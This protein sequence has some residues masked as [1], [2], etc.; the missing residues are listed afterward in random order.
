MRLR[1]VLLDRVLY[2]AGVGIPLVL[3][4]LALTRHRGDWPAQRFWIVYMAPMFA[5]GAWWA[6]ALLSTVGSAPA[7][8]V[9]IDAVAFVAG[10][11]RVSGGWGVI[12]YSGHVLF[13]TFVALS[14]SDRAFR[15]SAIGLLAVA[16]WFKLAL[17]HDWSSW[18]LGLM[19]GVL[20][21]IARRAADGEP[22]RQE[23][24]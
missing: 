2:I 13:L 1:L 17:W 23:R 4:G 6:R 16:T 24:A 20:L 3:A 10:G 12:P 5:F 15:W 8:V 7:K 22:G 14:A 19:V 21:A 18:I 9:I 11:I